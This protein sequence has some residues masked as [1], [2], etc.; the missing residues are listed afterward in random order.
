MRPARSV[1][2]CFWTSEFL[3]LSLLQR[4]EQSK[5]HSSPILSCIC[6]TTFPLLVLSLLCMR[7]LVMHA[8]THIAHI[9]RGW[10]WDFSFLIS[11]RFYR[12]ICRVQ[13]VAGKRK[14]RN[15]RGG[16]KV[17]RKLSSVAQDTGHTATTKK[18][19]VPRSLWHSP[20]VF[21]W[22]DKWN[23]EKESTSTAMPK[24]SAKPCPDLMQKSNF[25]SQLLFSLFPNVDMDRKD[26]REL[27]KSE[28]DWTRTHWVK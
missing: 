7:P 28:Q 16:K 20:R 13:L 23:T 9:L 11:S 21:N 18:R 4:C 22:N 3:S 5:I 25:L 1:D 19:T 2:I 15:I 24:P 10:K 17:N 8:I 27:M 12:I 26:R 6:V 14:R